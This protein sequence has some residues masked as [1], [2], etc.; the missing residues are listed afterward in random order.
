ML[1]K[2]ERGDECTLLHFAALHSALESK[3]RVVLAPTLAGAPITILVHARAMTLP[4]SAAHVRETAIL[5]D[6]HDHLL[7]QCVTGNNSA[8][9][10]RVCIKNNSSFGLN[11]TR[12]I[13]DAVHMFEPGDVLNDA[14]FSVYCMQLRNKYKSLRMTRMSLGGFT[15]APTAVLFCT[16]LI[17]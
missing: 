15:N 10:I 1:R 7:L 8:Y 6:V 4:S 5:F 3:Y 2:I 13:A 17:L 9:F 16:N 14:A 11:E 12:A